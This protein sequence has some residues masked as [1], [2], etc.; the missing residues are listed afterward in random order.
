MKRI[1]IRV[2]VLP[3]IAISNNAN[4]TDQQTILP[5]DKQDHLSLRSIHDFA[6]GDSIDLSDIITN[7]FPYRLFYHRDRIFDPVHTH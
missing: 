1:A 3:V 7:Q 2:D 5:R 6:H 4:L